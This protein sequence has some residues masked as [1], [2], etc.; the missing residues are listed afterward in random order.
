M[1]QCYIL[2]LGDFHSFK[3]LKDSFYIVEN[4]IYTMMV[5]QISTRFYL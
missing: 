4:F 3:S 5:N 2:L 1:D